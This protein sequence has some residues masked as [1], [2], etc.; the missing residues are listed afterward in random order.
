MFNYLKMNRLSICFLGLLLGFLGCAPALQ[1]P[2]PAPLPV[3]DLSTLTVAEKIAATSRE[4]EQTVQPA[5]RAELLLTLGLLHTHPDNPAPDYA[6][7]LQCLRQHAQ[8]DPQAAASEPIRRLTALL[9]AVTEKTDRTA[10]LAEENRHLAAEVDALGRKIQALE[11]SN[12]N[13]KAVIENLKN[14]DIRL[15]RRRNRIE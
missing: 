14:L 8:H 5:R 15:E 7:A 3:A 10:Q 11:R 12:R 13:M 6:R 9:T 1:D 2:A 4:L